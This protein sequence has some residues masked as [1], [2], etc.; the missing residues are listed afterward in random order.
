L[1]IEGVPGRDAI[2]LVK[3]KM[4]AL[5]EDHEASYKIAMSTDYEGHTGAGVS[6][7]ASL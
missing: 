4:K 7:V 2:E 3:A 6:A 5:T 1:W